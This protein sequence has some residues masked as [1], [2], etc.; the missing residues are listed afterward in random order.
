MIDH[1]M[2]AADGHKNRINTR[3]IETIVQRS[4]NQSI[5]LPYVA[6]WE[7]RN[8]MTHCENC[9]CYLGSDSEIKRHLEQ[10]HNIHIRLG[11]TSHLAYCE[12]TYVLWGWAIKN[13]RKR[14]SSG[15]IRSRSELT[16]FLFICTPELLLLRSSYAKT[17]TGTWA[18]R[19]K[20][21]SRNRTKPCRSICTNDTP[22]NCSRKTNKYEERHAD[23][24]E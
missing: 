11:S 17:A 5:Y 13:V 14:E 23:L 3:Q 7:K 9:N 22:S 1:D 20:C 12:G 6:E 15:L 16:P 4:T 10:V 19:K 2:I 18:R 8:S 21:A 24:N